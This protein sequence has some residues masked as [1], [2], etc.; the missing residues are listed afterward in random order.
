[1]HGCGPHAKSRTPAAA[2]APASTRAAGSAP[3]SRLSLPAAV[4]ATSAAVLPLKDEGAMKCYLLLPSQ[5]RELLQRQGGRLQAAPRGAL[6]LEPLLQV[7]RAAAGREGALWAEQGR[8]RAVAVEP[9]RSTRSSNP[10]HLPLPGLPQ[11]D[12]CFTCLH[13]RLDGQGRL[14]PVAAPPCAPDGVEESGG[15]GGGPG[16]AAVAACLAAS[17]VQLGVMVRKGVGGTCPLR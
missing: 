6:G 12:R 13:Y 15:G 3:L 10:C 7:R 9:P 17:N 2:A 11:Q 14:H 8:A 16:A 5:R 4:Q 1:M